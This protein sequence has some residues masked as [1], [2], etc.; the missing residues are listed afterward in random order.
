MSSRSLIL[1]TATRFL[2]PLLV[3][4]SIFVLLRGHN[5]PGGGFVGGLIASSAFALYALAFNVNSARRV[6]P[7]SPGLLFT[8][9]L[10]L[11]VFSGFAGLLTGQ[12]FMKGLW[13]ARE[14][15][16]IGKIGTPLFFDIGVYLVVLG[17]VLTIVFTFFDDI[18]FDEEDEA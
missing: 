13:S 11:A 7:S 4:F 1:T 12:E 17:V 8:I 3:L 5:E 10:T 18:D 6:L 16:V 2:L 14:V 9:G 15:P